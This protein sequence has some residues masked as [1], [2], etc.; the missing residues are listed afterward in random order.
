MCIENGAADHKSFKEE[1]ATTTNGVSLSSPSNNCSAS[2][3]A[4]EEDGRGAEKAQAE[5]KSL[6][7]SDDMEKMLSL[8]YGETDAVVKP[9]I[10]KM[11]SI[12]TDLTEDTTSNDDD[13]GWVL[14]L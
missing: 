14:I 8:D 9:R 3:S 2:T 6:S 7:R 13:D 10:A 5:P 12:N 1:G 11:N 4:F